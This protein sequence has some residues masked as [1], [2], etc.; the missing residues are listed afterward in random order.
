M[1]CYEPTN[2]TFIIR[3]SN[4]EYILK[5]FFFHQPQIIKAATLVLANIIRFLFNSNK[6]D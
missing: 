1:V 5:Y 3:D 4:Y 2:P 6:V